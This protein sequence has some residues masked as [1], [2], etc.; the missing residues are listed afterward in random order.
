MSLPSTFPGPERSRRVVVFT[1]R[2]CALLWLWGQPV[3]D[4]CPS[5]PAEPRLQPLELFQTPV[6]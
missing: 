6:F 2:P 3:V 1:S 5:L 4:R